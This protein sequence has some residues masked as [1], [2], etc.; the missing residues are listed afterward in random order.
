M[1]VCDGSGEILEV[2]FGLA[3]GEEFLGPEGDG[4]G[5]QLGVGLAGWG[6]PECCLLGNGQERVVCV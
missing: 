4:A 5:W 6:D 2:E 3:P 1:V